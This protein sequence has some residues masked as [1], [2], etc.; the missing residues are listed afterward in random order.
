[1]DPRS[2]RYDSFVPVPFGATTIPLYRGW[3]SVQ[4]HVAGRAVRFVNTHL[5]VQNFASFQMSQANELLTMLGDEPLPVLLV[6]DL[7]SA[8]NVVQTPTYG[9]MLDNG[10]VDTWAESPNVDDGLTC[11]QDKE[12][13]NA[14]SQH[15]QRLDFVLAR[16]FFTRGD[17]LVGSTRVEV[18]GEEPSDRTASGLW[19]ADHGGV[20]ATLHV[21][22]PNVVA[23]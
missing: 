3:T 8:A 12:L 21:P 10:F 13:L 20:A 16:G 7:N 11:C 14:D 4:L 2:D 5:E 18:V 19:P 1:M 23:W 15:D 22:H 9:Y 17:R 6:G